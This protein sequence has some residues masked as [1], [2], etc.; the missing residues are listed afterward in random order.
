[1]IFD[2]I[3]WNRGILWA[4][5]GNPRPAQIR[6]VGS[7][8]DLAPTMGNE[9]LSDVAGPGATEAPER[10]TRRERSFGVC[11]GQLPASARR[12][13]PLAAA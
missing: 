10:G 9:R 11:W 13:Q 6:M 1:M 5:Q 8:A 3:F 2:W 4:W 7:G 12:G